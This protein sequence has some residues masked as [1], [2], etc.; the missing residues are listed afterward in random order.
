[1]AVY[2]LTEH[3]TLHFTLNQ[4]MSAVAKIILRLLIAAAILYLEFVYVA[5]LSVR[6]SVVLAM[7]FAFLLNGAIHAATK[8]PLKFKRYWIKI[9][10]KWHEILTDFKLVNTPEAWKVV[11]D[12]SGSA[13]R[14]GSQFFMMDSGFQFFD[15]HPK[16]K[17]L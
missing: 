2:S 9:F 16:R 17:K 14:H 12:F 1:M 7:L 11:Q 4:Y 5:E 8:P 6:Q 15:H 3:A 13:S 10:P